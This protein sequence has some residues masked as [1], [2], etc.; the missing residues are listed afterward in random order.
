MKGKKTILSEYEQSRDDKEK[1]K[2]GSYQKDGSL[3]NKDG[4][5]LHVQFYVALGFIQRRRAAQGPPR[6]SHGPAGYRATTSV[7]Y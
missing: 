2:L 6:L 1:E 5:L 7:N 4:S 3:L